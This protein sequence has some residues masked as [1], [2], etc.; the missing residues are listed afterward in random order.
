MVE[1]DENSDLGE[2]LLRLTGQEASAVFPLSDT[3]NN[4]LSGLRP[5]LF[6]SMSLTIQPLPTSLLTCF[7]LTNAHHFIP[8]VQKPS[9]TLPPPALRA[10]FPPPVLLPGLPCTEATPMPAQEPFPFFP[11]PHPSTLS[12]SISLTGTNTVPAPPLSH[13]PRFRSGD[14]TA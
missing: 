5:L 8:E 3:R 1:L 4:P 10:T 2:L 11:S 13:I 7:Q 9:A 6:P 14:A 12:L